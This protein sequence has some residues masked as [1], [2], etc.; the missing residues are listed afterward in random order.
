MLRGAAKIVWLALGSAAAGIVGAQNLTTLAG[1]PLTYM[2]K[3]DMQIYRDALEAAL[4]S[5]KD[6]AVSRWENPPTKA[7]GSI[8]PV[9]SFKLGD[10]DCRDVYTDSYAQGRREKGTHAFCK[11]GDGIW[12]FTPGAT[13]KK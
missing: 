12:K 7:S 11:G 13:G 1:A 4:E 3:E 10:R 2:T 9:R 8:K 6:G 5:G